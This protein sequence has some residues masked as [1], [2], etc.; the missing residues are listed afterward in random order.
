MSTDIGYSCFDGWG[1]GDGDAGEDLS[2]EGGG[3]G[4]EL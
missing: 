1:F 4:G 2:W 3:Y